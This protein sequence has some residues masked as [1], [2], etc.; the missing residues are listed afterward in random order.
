MPTRLNEWDLFKK[1]WWDD[2]K[3]A[4]WGFYQTVLTGILF[5]PAISILPI[6]FVLDRIDVKMQERRLRKMKG[7]KN[8]K[9]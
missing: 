3:G 1:W 4:W 7:N 2:L 6:I 5:L 8:G 9:N